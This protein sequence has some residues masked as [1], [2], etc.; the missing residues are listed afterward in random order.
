M[1]V[2]SMAEVPY[3]STLRLAA[4]ESADPGRVVATV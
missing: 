1:D 2:D 4:S 3:G